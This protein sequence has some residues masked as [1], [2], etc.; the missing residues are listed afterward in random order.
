MTDRSGDA[1][2]GAPGACGASLSQQARRVAVGPTEP[3]APPSVPFVVGLISGFQGVFVLTVSHL[4][5]A[6][7]RLLVAVAGVAAQRFGGSGAPAADN[8]SSGRTASGFR[9][10]PLL[11]RVV[12]ALGLS[13]AAA[14]L[15]ALAAPS[16]FALSNLGQLSGTFGQLN[17]ESVAVNDANGHILVA[18]SAVGLVYDY[19]SASDTSPTTWD[20]SNTPAGSFGGG[21]VAVAADNSTGDV[22]VADATDAVID[23]F[24]SSGALIASFGDTTPS[25]DGQLAGLAAPSGSF[26]P[27]QVTTFG[28][29]VDQATHDLYAIDAGHQVVDV[30]DSTGAYQS[31]ITATPAG[32]YAYSGNYA[33]GIAVNA[34]T[35]HVF[36]SDSGPV[37]TFEFD[38]S[39]AYVRTLTGSGTPAGSFGL[40]FTSVATS[41]ATGDLYVLDTQDQVVDVLDSAGNFLSQIAGTPVGGPFGGLAAGQASGNVYVSDDGASP[42]VKIFGPGPPSIDAAAAQDLTATTAD[43]T[44]K[45]NPNGFDTTYHFDWGTDTSYG[46]TAPVPDGDIGSGG[47]DVAVSAHLSGLTANTTYHWRVVAT[48]A[49]GTVGASADHTFI[50]D[51]TG[52]ALP[53]NRAYEQVTPAQKNGALIGVVFFSAGPPNVAA[54]GS[55]VVSPSI[56]C[57][58][59]A[60]ACNGDRGVQGDPVAFTRSPSGWISTALAPPAS[61]FGQ[62]YPVSYGGDVGAVLFSVPTAPAYQ[63]DFYARLG[64]GS[65]V[66][67]GPVTPPSGGARAHVF[68][69]SATAATADLSHLLYQLDCT[70]GDCWPF[71]ATTRQGGSSS[72][73]EYVGAGNTQPLLVGVS[74]G[75]GSTD[76]ISVCGDLLGGGDGATYNALSGDGATVFFTARQCASGSGANAATPVPADALYARIDGERAD[77]RTVAIS[78]PS[79]ADCTIPACTGSA[80]AAAGFQGASHDGSRVFFTSTQQLTN[81]ASEDT[82]PGD[83]AGGATECSH[84]TGSGGC[85]LYL[86]DFGKAA[87]HELTAVSAGDASGGGPRVQGVMAISPDGS[88]VYFVAKGVLS[89]DPNAQGQ[90]AHDGA[91][92]LYDYDVATGDTTFISPLAGSDS[93][94]PIDGQS[95][96]GFTHGVGLANVTADGRFLVFMSYGQLTTDDHSSQAQVFRYDAQTGRLIRI[97]VGNDGFSDNGNGGVDLASIVPAFHGGSGRT[98]PTM[99]RDGSRIF[100]RDPAA[101]TPG[102]LDNIQVGTVSADPIYAQNVYEWHSGHVSLISDGRDVSAIATPGGNGLPTDATSSVGLLGTDT[103]GDNVFFTTTDRLVPQDGDTQLDYYDARVGGGFPF[104]PPSEPCDGDSCQG[105]AGGQPVPPSAA[106]VTFSGPG[107]ATRP[108]APAKVK[109]LSTVVHGSRFSVAVKVPG[110]GR[111]TISGSGI[112]P[113]GKSVGKAGTYK[114]RV[115]LT[116]KEARTLKR[117][118]KVKLRPRVVFAPAGGPSSSVTVSLTVKA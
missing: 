85:N 45:I 49:N 40:G 104:T 37:Q 36:V 7:R 18:D 26:S 84:T 92:N 116:A 96:G 4:V 114:V 24:D 28:I 90:I 106:S 23:K 113:V 95:V 75:P 72:L 69:S 76:L 89:T 34:T 118:H 98:D 66:D 99:S 39:G 48:N 47:T 81:A 10:H 51:T 27:A 53:D 14:A 5:Q 56:Q 88:R 41:D 1:G 83:A 103:T 97:S 86:Y 82:T 115:G 79:P 73:Y 91:Y 62:N 3:V 112:K 9:R 68:G 55:G 33:D 6:V 20:G 46:N 57:F 60:A 100:F 12:S 70:G 29:T 101:L 105:A 61:Q 30:F 71:D 64:D 25:P 32:L 2:A 50:Y 58:G 74:G 65:L 63:D 87:G 107:N 80:A 16:A 94:F 15:L 43:L 109:I 22:Y 110:K 54:D 17:S 19:A 31:Q 21:A 67:V 108:A 77:A 59:D 13:L 52:H 11:G 117:K 44:A 93:A 8:R 111:I 102:A 35:G 78:Q 42:V 38:G